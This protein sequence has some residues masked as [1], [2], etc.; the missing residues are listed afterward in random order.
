M[1]IKDRSGKQAHTK[2]SDWVI[3]TRDDDLINDPAVVAKSA[4]IELI[5]GLKPWTD[6][7]SNVFKIFGSAG[8]F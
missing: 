2:F 5:A 8:A 1:L 3:V 4:N 7:F 6:D